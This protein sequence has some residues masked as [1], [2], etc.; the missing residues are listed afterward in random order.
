M[1]RGIK[2]I[3]GYSYVGIYLR[4]SSYKDFYEEKYRDKFYSF[5]SR[6]SQAQKMNNNITLLKINK[7]N[8]F[9]FC[10][11]IIY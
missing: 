3:D 10:P 11:E 5:F 7:V 9:G 6:I 8:Y 4:I 2:I 1:S